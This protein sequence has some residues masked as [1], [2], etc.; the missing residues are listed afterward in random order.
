MLRRLRSMSRLSRAAYSVIIFSVAVRSVWLAG[1]WFKEDDL[2]YRYRANVFG[3]DLGFWF[4]R[5]D[6]HLMPGS[7]AQVWVLE[8]VFGAAWWP[9]VAWCAVLQIAAAVLAW[10]LFRSLFGERPAVLVLV[11]ALLWNPIS[12]DATLWW[13]VGMQFLPLQVAFF[14]LVLC[15][16]RAISRYP[17]TPISRQRLRSRAAIYERLE[18]LGPHLGAAG[19]AAVV[20]AV[21]LAFSEKSLLMAPFVVVLALAA[22]L[23]PG[24]A[25]LADRFRSVLLPAAALSAVA[26]GWVV[27]YLNTPSNQ[28]VS[29]FPAASLEQAQ[30]AGWNLMSRTFVPSLIGGPWRWLQVGQT[31]AVSIPTDVAVKL[32]MLLGI[33]VAAV[34][35]LRRPRVLWV[36]CSL[37]V[38]AIT[39]V[40]ALAMPGAG[41]I[42]ILGPLAGQVPRYSA[43]LVLPGLLVLG[44]ATLRNIA[45]PSTACDRFELPAGLAH[46][47]RQTAFAW[48]MA[49]AVVVSSTVTSSKLADI[50]KN[51]PARA[52]SNAALESIASVTGDVELVRQAAP[53]TVI[54][55]LFFPDNGTHVV[56]GPLSPRFVFPD[57][58]TDPHMV[59]ADGRIVPARVDGVAIGDGEAC[60]AE[61]KGGASARVDLPGKLWAWDWY[62]T[63]MYRAATETF[64]ETSFGDAT[65]GAPIVPPSGS[66]TFRMVSEGDHL[67]FEV[68][69]GILCITQVR[70]GV[71][72]EVTDEP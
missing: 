34:T 15:V 47:G 26:A 49:F 56:L 32:S 71:P 58:L 63:V 12:L 4:T 64:L 48:T 1:T 24:P 50:Q 21:A 45:E 62:V 28:V 16:R 39:A 20:L 33:A 18:Q 70:I 2:A 29:D 9:V 61:A 27:L 66:V 37:L 41:R 55:P 44:L 57:V 23:A 13:A 30:D 72:V 19:L 40:A 69:S 17:W 52:F 25:R 6:G 68:L 7:L 31:A 46:P 59:S 67:G 51:A 3:L 11:V 65:V 38:Y 53:A 42:S 35:I 14:A 43:E 8:K 5:R 22:P 36:W 10:R 60:V 54:S